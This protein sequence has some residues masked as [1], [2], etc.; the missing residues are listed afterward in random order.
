V[1]LDS[2]AKRERPGRVSGKTWS[3]TEALFLK[4][5]LLLLLDRETENYLG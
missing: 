2:S 4:G 3:E 1:T 5:R